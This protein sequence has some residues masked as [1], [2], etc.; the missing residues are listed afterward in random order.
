MEGVSGGTYQVLD[1]ATEFWM[2]PTSAETNTDTPELIAHLSLLL[3]WCFSHRLL[4]AI[5]ESQ[6]EELNLHHIHVRKH[7]LQDGRRLR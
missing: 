3:S 4:F 6:T 7:Q 2:D 1:A 5:T